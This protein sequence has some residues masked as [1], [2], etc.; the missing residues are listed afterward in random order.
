M[1]WKVAVMLMLGVGVLYLIVR[2]E[3]DAQRSP[4]TPTAPAASEF[5]S[6][7]HR[8]DDE[9]TPEAS[10]QGL[11]SS[12]D[13]GYATTRA[14]SFDGFQCSVDCS[15]HEAGYNWA[16]EHDIDDEDDCETAGDNSN[17]PSFGEGCK[18]YVNG[19]SA[20]DDSEKTEDQ[21]VDQ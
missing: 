9:S 21:D 2:S 16:E 17:S 15:G 7:P 14:E 8:S 13:R 5:Q 18:A 11:G 1:N 10:S 4:G 3:P 12:S 6:S 19:G 20:E